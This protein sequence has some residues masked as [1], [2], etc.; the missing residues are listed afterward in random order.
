MDEAVGASR[1]KQPRKDFWA[2]MLSNGSTMMRF[3]GI[4]DSAMVIASEL[5]SKQTI[6][7]ELQREL[8]DE[9]RTLQE[10]A[11]GCFINE[12]ISDLKAQYEKELR[13]LDELRKQSQESDHTMKRKIS[14][15]LGS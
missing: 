10:T 7:L 14:T 9:G 5:M 13:D 15:R 1:E 12:N 4:K 2:Y 8:V 11:A 6:V 3:H